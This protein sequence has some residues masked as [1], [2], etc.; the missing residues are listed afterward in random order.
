M[1]TFIAL[2]FIFFKEKDLESRHIWINLGI[3]KSSWS[4]KS[5]SLFSN[6]NIYQ[7]RLES[8]LQNREVSCRINPH[9]ELHN[10]A[11]MASSATQSIPFICAKYWTVNEQY[12]LI[13][14][15][16]R[17]VILLINRELKILPAQKFDNV[18]ICLSMMKCT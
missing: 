14:Q 10:V 9:T 17:F 3:F 1:D 11:V 16:L 2:C 18:K 5:I 4:L 7:E 12:L 13:M 15:N 8:K 6:T